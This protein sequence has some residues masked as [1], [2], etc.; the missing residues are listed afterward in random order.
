MDLT[1]VHDYRFHRTPDGAV[2]TE[3]AYDHSFWERYLRVF[4]RVK[5][6][7]R[8]K[9]VAE[10]EETWLRV[11]G[12]GV[13]VA[14]VPYY[15]GPLHFLARANQ[16]RECI[17]SALTPGSAVILRIPS[18][19]SNCAA[20]ILQ[21]RGVPYGVE[22]VGDPHAA[23]AKKVV[24]HPLRPLLRWWFTRN[25]RLQCSAA[26][27]ASYVSEGLRRAYRP[28][29][30]ASVLVCSD[31]R[32]DEDW[33]VPVPRTYKDRQ[34]LNL[35]T[36][37][38]LSQT[39]KGTGVLIEAVALCAGC[40]MDVRL[41]IVGDGRFRRHFERLADTLGIGERVRFAGAIAWGP[42]L[43]SELDAAD[44]FVLPSLVEAMPRALL[45]AMA[46]GLPCIG[47]R[48]GA[49]AELLDCEDLA[50][51]GRVVHLAAKICR[52]LRT[53]ERLE[54]MSARNLTRARECAERLLQPRWEA[55]HRELANRTSRFYLGPGQRVVSWE[56][57]EPG[58][59][60]SPQ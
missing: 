5:L 54:A 51:P 11:D 9:A 31:V 43:W 4:D 53:P 41:T 14:A 32:L 17:T 10:R 3:T 6:I 25:Q 8:V 55:F 12:N 56:N 1:Y 52:V 28:G 45:E 24:K 34:P 48:V 35:I 23:M 40:D 38:T 58:K 21:R 15:L 22:V 59:A 33:F 20:A 7:S 50:P 26:L 29:R 13:S 18:Q 19:L 57:F 46:R 37:G 36:V 60:G 49:V 27:G 47:S 44:L 16:V 30:G 42:P 2:W 39:Y